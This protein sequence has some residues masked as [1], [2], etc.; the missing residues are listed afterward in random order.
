MRA[1]LEGGDRTGSASAAIELYGAEIMRFLLVRLRDRALAEDGYSTF[2]E[3]LWLGLPSFA[4]R[5]SLRTWLFVLARH[6][7]GRQLRERLRERRF[8]AAEEDQAFDQACARVRT[9]TAPYMRTETKHRVRALRE[10]LDDDQQTLLILR[11]ER[12]LPWR[13]LA[14]VMGEAALDADEPELERATA[15]VRMRYQAAKKRLRALAMEAGLLTN[16]DV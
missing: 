8:A 2:C 15:R 16:Q 1:L 9:Q 11:V 7:C 4:W 3:D 14:L 13:D 6:A 5:S 12:G 10:L